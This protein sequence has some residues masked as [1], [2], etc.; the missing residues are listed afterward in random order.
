MLTP[1]FRLVSRALVASL[2]L[3]MAAAPAVAVTNLSFTFSQTGYSEGATVTGAFTGA[4]LDGNGLLVHFPA[5]GG[6]PIAHNE[7]TAWSMHF[8]GNSLSPAFDLSLDDLYGFVY[9]LGT[10]GIGDDPAYDPTIDQD[11][12]EGVGAIG[13]SHFYTAGLGPN[14]FIG[15]YVGGE[16]TGPG[17]EVED[18]AL[19]STQNLALVMLVPEPAAATLLLAAGPALAAAAR[20]KA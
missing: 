20:R 2:A 12:I 4:D 1:D 6:P 16:I 19:D 15:A 17:E 13:E 18:H 10:A 9:Q 14:S 5:T 8:S 7:L 11:L 3:V